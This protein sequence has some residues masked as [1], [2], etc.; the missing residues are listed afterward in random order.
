MSRIGRCHDCRPELT[1]QGM[2]KIPVAVTLCPLHTMG[3]AMR[4]F[5]ALVGYGCGLTM[6][7]LAATAKEIIRTI[8]HGLDGSR[9]RP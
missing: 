1:P 4:T 3:E 8:D 2:V 6:E 7:S 9:G 5:V